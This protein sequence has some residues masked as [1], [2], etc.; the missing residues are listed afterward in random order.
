M[1]RQS[2]SPRVNRQSEAKTLEAEAE[3]K[4]R[5]RK[6][7]IKNIFPLI[8]LTPKEDERETERC[9][10]NGGRDPGH[11]IHNRLPDTACDRPDGRSDTPILE[12]QGLAAARM[13]LGPT[14]EPAIEIQEISLQIGIGRDVRLLR[15]RLYR[16]GD[17][18]AE[19][20]A[21]EAKA[22]DVIVAG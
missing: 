7:Y 15:A 2:N 17:Y 16:G 4:D 12:E 3:A 11:Q 1:F 8:A 20:V 13:A 19:G 5:T 21:F 18:G 6:A 22:D 14:P 9:E 10:E